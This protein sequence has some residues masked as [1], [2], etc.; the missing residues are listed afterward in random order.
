VCEGDRWHH[1]LVAAVPELRGDRILLNAHADN[2]AAAPRG[3]RGLGDRVAL[4]LVAGP[5][6]RADGAG[7][8]IDL[9]ERTKE[10][11]GSWFGV[12]SCAGKIS[13]WEELISRC[14]LRLAAMP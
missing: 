8:S 5:F 2:E 11:A 12:S 9:P 7:C 10:G 4:R 3:P 14:S 1:G 6:N 13:L